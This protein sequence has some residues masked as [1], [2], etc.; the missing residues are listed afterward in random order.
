MPAKTHP[1]SFVDLLLGRST[2]CLLAAAA[3]TL[4]A[5][6]SAPAKAQLPY[7]FISNDEKM[8]GAA[9]LF[10]CAEYPSILSVQKMQAFRTLSNLDGYG[11]IQRRTESVIAEVT[12]D[13]QTANE[14]FAAVGSKITVTVEE[15]LF[16]I[17]QLRTADLN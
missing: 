10:I 17:C 4:A 2:R 8:N 14:K 1:A 12:K 11:L 6:S 5:L 9:W 3:F 15:R 13:V 16:N 7:S